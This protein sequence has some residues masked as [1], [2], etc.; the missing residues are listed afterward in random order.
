MNSAASVKAYQYGLANR[1]RTKFIYA[2]EETFKS[3]DLIA[4]PTTPT[5]SYKVTET[6]KKS[7]TSFIAEI[8]QGFHFSWCDGWEVYN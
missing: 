8:I 2:F 1:L 5:R 3:V 6:D 4:T 7:K